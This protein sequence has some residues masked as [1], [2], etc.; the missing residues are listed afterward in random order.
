MKSSPSLAE[1]STVAPI[2]YW[3][4]F[5]IE[6]SKQWKFQNFYAE[7]TSGSNQLDGG[8]KETG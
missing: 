4:E 8:D 7:E 1:N 2:T 6:T 5:C 3:R